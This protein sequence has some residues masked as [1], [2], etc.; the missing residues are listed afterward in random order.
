MPVRIASELGR[1]EFVLVALVAGDERAGRVSDR[2][3]LRRGDELL[4][5]RR[6]SGDRRA[7]G[8]A[9]RRHPRARDPD[10]ARPPRCP[11][12]WSWAATASRSTSCSARWRERGLH[13]P[14]HRGRQ[15]G[16]R[17]RRPSAA[18][19]TSRRCTSSIPP[20]ASTTPICCGRARAGEGLAAHAGLRAPAGRSRALPDAARP[21]RSRRRSPIPAA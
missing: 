4:P 12:S 6:L 21:T 3:G 16:R 13:R 17:R 7:R 11:I 9:R 10:R 15:H 18:N 20:A 14:H 8:R 1:K 5:G 2:Q 19:A